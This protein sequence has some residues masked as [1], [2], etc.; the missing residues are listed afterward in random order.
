MPKRLDELALELHALERVDGSSFHR[1]ACVL[2]S[3]WRTEQALPYGEYRG[4]RLGARL[5]TPWAQ[6]TLA[7]Y[8]TDMVRAVVRS[9][10]LDRRKSAGTLYGRPRIFDDLLSSQPLAF[11]LLA[12]L[13]ANLNARCAARW[14][15]E[16]SLGWRRSSRK[17]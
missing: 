10:V 14:P 15:G 2:Q 13:S 16:R 11:K 8:L 12:E 5:P 17:G 7:N 3:L 9:E 6:K 1:R 4:R